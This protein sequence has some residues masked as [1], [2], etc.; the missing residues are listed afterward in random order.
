MGCWNLEI[1]FL[2]L[3]SVLGLWDLGLIRVLGGH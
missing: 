2:S 3:E 1:G